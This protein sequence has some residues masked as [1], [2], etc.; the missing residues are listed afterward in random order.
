MRHQQ[1]VQQ[2]KEATRGFSL[3]FCSPERGGFGAVAPYR[4]EDC[5]PM[6]EKTRYSKEGDWCWCPECG[7]M[8]IHGP[9]QEMHMPCKVMRRYRITKHG[10]AA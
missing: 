3:L 1:I 2:W 8:E 6:W 9:N 7:R 10:R 4:C 5:G